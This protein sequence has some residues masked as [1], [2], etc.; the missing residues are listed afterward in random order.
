MNN[1]NTDNSYNNGN[2][3]EYN[4]ENNKKINAGYKYGTN[5][6]RVSSFVM[7]R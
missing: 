1:S 5:L 2:V 7:I 3:N 6:C 4:I